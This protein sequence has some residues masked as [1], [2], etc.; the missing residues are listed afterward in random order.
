MTI[1]T[2]TCA[3]AVALGV[4]FLA[5]TAWT[6]DPAPDLEAQQKAMMDLMMKLA[7]P[8]PQHKLLAK[9]E[10]DWDV[11][12]R[13][14]P[15]GKLQESKGF[16]RNRMVL[17]G[18]Y[19]QTEWRGEM[20]DMPHNGIGMMGF[21]NAQGH[22]HSQWYDSM[23]TGCYTLVGQAAEDGSAISSDGTWTM[24]MPD[25]NTMTMKTRM[26]YTFK[27]ADTF[28]MEHYS[29]NQGQEVREM[30][31]TYKRRKPAAKPAAAKPG[32]CPPRGKG[33]GY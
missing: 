14:W 32:C 10:G 3:L 6:E 22:Y 25:G 5:G 21:D 26:V 4:G 33:P 13:A 1:R 24:K 12:S 29:V 7:E 2:I 17:G 27:D 15:M 18:R 23:G 11:D 8:G 31:L 16:C 19:L 20:F 28:V 30:E 9:M